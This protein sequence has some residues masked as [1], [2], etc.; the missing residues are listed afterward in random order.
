MLDSELRARGNEV[1]R[2]WSVIRRG[3]QIARNEQLSR[4]LSRHRSE[5]VPTKSGCFRYQKR[6]QSGSARDITDRR[7]GPAIFEKTRQRN[8]NSKNLCYAAVS[9]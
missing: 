2:Y 4:G 6:K 1:R 9:M 5:A 8:K 3:V 7:L